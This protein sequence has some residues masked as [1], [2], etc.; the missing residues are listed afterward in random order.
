[1][2]SV[3]VRIGDVT[4]A[5]VLGRVIGGRWRLRLPMGRG[6]SGG[7]LVGAE[8]EARGVV[9]AAALLA[10]AAQIVGGGNKVEMGADILK[11]DKVGETKR[12]ELDIQKL[13]DDGGSDDA[14]KKWVPIRS[15]GN[16]SFFLGLNQ[17]I[18]LSTATFP[19]LRTNC[20]YI[21]RDAVYRMSPENDTCAATRE[22]DDDLRTH[23]IYDLR[24]EGLDE[25]YSSE[26]FYS[27]WMTPRLPSKSTC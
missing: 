2:R 4:R 6:W 14:N 11:L 27:L 26:P 25:Y 24:D 12:R 10:P 18:S 19:R 17:S 15:L 9:A 8:Q 13:M 16:S 20:I 7:G 1:M 22:D 3:G 5:R 21:P 23:L